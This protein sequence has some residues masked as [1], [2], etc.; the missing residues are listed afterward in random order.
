VL[1]KKEGEPVTGNHSTCPWQGFRTP[2]KSEFLRATSQSS[3]F[4]LFQ[5]N[6]S[7]YLSELLH[8]SGCI[9]AVSPSATDG[10]S[11]DVHKEYENMSYDEVS[12]KMAESYQQLSAML[13]TNLTSGTPS[14]EPTASSATSSAHTTPVLEP[15]E[16]INETLILN[17][18]D[19]T[20]DEKQAKITRIFS[21]AASNGD[22]EK[23]KEML[24]TK[25]L[26][27]FIDIDARDED[28]T[29][30]L[31]YSACFGKVDVALALL[32]AGAKVDTQDKCTLFKLLV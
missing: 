9:M 16:F 18:Q 1:I 5:S 30:P 31:I 21:R 10:E 15:D 20:E 27:P 28:G 25:E 32:D 7:P 2:H 12:Q 17:K 11:K 26:R 19:L 24:A 22:V 8:T 29:T 14:D 3:P 6:F 23:I 4:S 13:G